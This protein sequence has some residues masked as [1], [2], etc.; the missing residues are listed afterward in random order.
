[1]ST[2][3]AFAADP[4][5]DTRQPALPRP[6]VEQQLHTELP[7]NK[8]KDLTTVSGLIGCVDRQAG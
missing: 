5:N 8:A 4:G 3:A 7:G 2:E 6:H 1:V